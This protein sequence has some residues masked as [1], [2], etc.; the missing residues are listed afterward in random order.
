MAELRSYTGFLTLDVVGAPTLAVNDS[1]SFPGDVSQQLSIL[2]QDDDPTLDGDTVTKEESGDATDNQVA[3]VTNS[4][5]SVLLDGQEV[6]LEQSFTFNID[7]GPDQTGYVIENEGSA[8]SIIVLPENVSP[9]TL[10][11]TSVNEGA[12][13]VAY[14]ADLASGAEAI[15]GNDFSDLDLSGDDVI[16]GGDGDDTID[17]GEGNDSVLGG[18]GADAIV[19]NAGGDTIEGG[20]GDDLIRGDSD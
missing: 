7:G 5:G 14:D 15:N 1:F 4:D 8:Q 10:T 16:E 2:I 19:G 3:F 20:A 13:G 17:A 11:V 18:D 12:T 6:Y 9:G